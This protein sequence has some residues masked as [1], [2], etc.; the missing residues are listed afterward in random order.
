M[1]PTAKPVSDLLKLI[2]I[3]TLF[4]FAVSANAD[5]E[6]T[7]NPKTADSSIKIRWLLAHEPARVF[8]RAAKQFKSEVELESKGAVVIEILTSSQYR[9]KYGLEKRFERAGLID[10]VALLQAGGIEMTQT[11]TTELGRLNPKMWVFDLPFL[12]K[13]HVHAKK[14][15]DGEV[16]KKILAG[17]LNSDVRGLAFTYSGGYRV[18]STRNV[19]LSTVEDFKNLT[20]RTSRSPVARSMFKTLGAKVVQMSH[21]EGVQSVKNGSLMAAETTVARLDSSQQ[22]ATPI[23]NDTQ[24]SLFLTSMVVNEKFFA[25]LPKNVQQVIQTAARNAA[26]LERQDSLTDEARLRK[27]FDKNG[28]NVVRMSPAEVAKLKTETRPLYAEFKSLFGAEFIESIEN[29]K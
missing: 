28:I 10:D 5:S 15:M 16:G 12:F 22:E 7:L 23:L 29:A 14:I 24:H 4:L 27:E 26:E 6:K 13:D 3:S 11:Y 9:E 18:I 8:E 2:A 20:I 17:L 21:D 1:K 25:Q 19:K